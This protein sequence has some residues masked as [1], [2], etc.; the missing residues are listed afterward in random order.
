MILLSFASNHLSAQNNNS[1]LVKE[2]ILSNGMTVW[3]NEDHS[4]PKVFGAVV[5]KAGAKDSPDT[6]IAHYF[7]HIMF[8]GTGKIGTIDYQK[9]KILLDAIALKYDELAAT[10]NPKERLEIQKEIN[11]LSGQASEF[12]IP[13]EFNRLISQYGGTQL[14]AGTSYDYTVYMNTFSPEYMAQW[15]EL[16]SERLINPVFRMFQTE[17]ETVYEEKNMY[18]DFMGRDAMDK[19]MERYFQPHPYAYSILGSTE[20][21]KNPQLS[22][23]QQFFEEYYVASN[24][25]LIL[26]GDFDG[27]KVLPIL[28]ATFSRI[29]KGEAP[30]K[31]KIE[32]PPFTGEE[33]F[34]VKF[35]IPIINGVGFAFRSVPANHPDQIP[36][37]IV[38][39]LLNNSNGTGYLDKLMINRKL[40]AAMTVNENLNEAGV[41]AVIGIPKLVIQ[42][43]VKAKELIWNEINRIKAGDF[44]DEMFNSL[45]LEQKRKY[46][47]HLED[48]SSRAEAMITMFSQGKSWDEYVKEID[49]I[50]ALTKEDVMAIAQKYFTDNYLYVTKTTG[51]YKKDNL[52]KPNFK[53][54]IPKYPEAISDYAL[55]LEKI[56]VKEVTPRFLDLQKDA[57]RISLS[58]LATLYATVNPV[59][60]IFTLDIS[61]GIGKV[62]QPE[63][64]QLAAYLPFL[65]TETLSFDD[66]RGKLQSLGS[67]LS[68]VV[69]ENRFAV[70]ISGFDTEFDETLSLVADFMREAQA[71]NKKIKQL[72]DEEKVL[73]KAFYKSTDQLGTALSEMVRYGEK[74]SYLNKL[75]LSDIKKLKGEDLLDIFRETQK[76]ACEFYYCGTLQDIQVTEKI[77]N[78][79]AVDQ[80][81][82]PSASPV[83]RL[84]KPYEEPTIFLYNMPDARQSIVYSLVSGDPVEDTYSRHIA[85]LFSGYFGGDMSSLMFQEI[86]EYRSFAYRTQGLYK[87]PVMQHKDKPG[88]FVTVLSTQT[89]KTLDA[90]EVLDSLIR[91]MPVKA[92]RLPAVKQTIVNRVSTSYPTF[93]KIPEKVALY[94]NEGCAVDPNISLLEDISS[95]EMEDVL[96]FYQQHVQDRP[97]VYMI[98]GNTKKIDQKQLARFGK[99]VKVNKNEI[100]K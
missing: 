4:Q 69:D 36:L 66:F 96:K 70:K 35:P 12:V 20:N 6:G 51:K 94:L 32:L 39:G 65:G 59:N 19:F 38:M 2:H 93:R 58:P 41:L 50:N 97:V 74:S 55:E 52:P 71:D 81:T 47:S 8:K 49:H 60:D 33:E 16:N 64:V 30:V 87:L 42:T 73:R 80:I 29:R 95:M 26:S 15:A 23:M 84:V 5:V 67:T 98:V 85:R 11:E 63:L 18:H 57:H 92:E 90:M 37:N 76:V 72:A 75:S 83:Y 14:N 27:E 48:I 61:Y 46:V 91:Q 9:E 40:M 89:D 22:E 99:I 43:R 100:Y 44:T 68:F 56:P 1:L 53:P 13:N 88:E 28:E 3:L 34:L 24:M 62:E 31:E 7:E 78:H 10:G 21:L 45:K 82:V 86:R 54:I 25:G 17:L 79:I 77:K